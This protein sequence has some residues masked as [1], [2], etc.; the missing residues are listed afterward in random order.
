MKSFWP[1]IF[2]FLNNI[3]PDDYRFEILAAIRLILC[4]FCFFDHILLWNNRSHFRTLSISNTNT[5]FQKKMVISLSGAMFH[6]TTLICW[7]RKLRINYNEYDYIVYC[8]VNIH[9]SPVIGKLVAYIPSNTDTNTEVLID[10]IHFNEN[11]LQNY[12]QPYLVT[13]LTIWY[14]YELFII[15]ELKSTYCL[16]VIELLT[17]TSNTYTFRQFVRI[18]IAFPSKDIY[19]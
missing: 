13:Y 18:W 9:F 12:G 5:D 10:E 17:A 6:T 4:L 11:S 2:F 8:T 16:I 1:K 3:L 15:I 14:P 7:I 19:C